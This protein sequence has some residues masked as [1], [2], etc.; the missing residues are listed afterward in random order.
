MMNTNHHVKRAVCST[1]A[2]VVLW[3]LAARAT[4]L[5]PDPDNAAL[6]YYQAC[7]LC[8]EPDD[9]TDTQMRRVLW[10]A[11][12]D[13]KV[14]QYVRLRGDT[15]ELAEA[16]AQ[17]PKCDWGAWYSQGHSP[18]LEIMGKVHSLACL[19]EVS[20]AVLAADG[21]CR[22]AL[23]RCLTI[24]RMAR[25]VGDDALQVYVMSVGTDG[26]SL[27]AI[28]HVLG[29]TPPDAETLVWF[30]NELV[31][32]TGALESLARAM[33]ME[34]ELTVQ[35]LRTDAKTLTWLRGEL[36][37]SARDRRAEEE[38]RSLTD[39][40]VVAR[41]REG[42]ADFLKSALAVLRTHMPYEKTYAEIQSL[43]D[44]LKEQAET[45]PAI[46]RAVRLNAEDLGRAYPYQIR[47]RAHFNMVKS[48]IE[49]YLAM[50]KTGQLLDT[51]PEGLPKDP[52]SGQG[53]EYEKTA[54][55]FLLRCRVKPVDERKLQEYEFKVRK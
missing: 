38:I 30:K 19:L 35:W 4:A 34:F 37:E 8:R 29:T 39:E 5:P 45:N 43:I 7:L 10:G 50:A 6:L 51:L 44:K 23:E 53:F 27:R 36:A 32:P 47:H 40:E 16:A 12:P 54:D 9:A 18:N 3:P 55:G 13:E 48:A 15:I 52:Y 1:F 28:R 21:H 11:K 22:A 26:G 14:R 31:A 41:V 25:H 17:I 46:F 24:R 33:E 49:I 2:A 42:Y 20:A